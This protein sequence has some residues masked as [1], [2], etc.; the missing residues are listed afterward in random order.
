MD[1]LGATINRTWYPWN[2]K[3]TGIEDASCASGL[4]DVEPK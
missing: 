2:M 1:Q 3:K 4:G